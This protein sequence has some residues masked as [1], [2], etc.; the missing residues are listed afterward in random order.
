MDSFQKAM[1]DAQEELARIEERRT[2]LLQLVEDLKA[3]SGEESAELVPPPGYEPEGLTAEIRKILGLST[4]HLTAVQ[5]R[6]SLVQRGFSK[7][8]PKNLLIA[9]HTV[10][11]RIEKELDVA[12]REGKPVYKAKRSVNFLETLVSF[13]EMCAE[14]AKQSASQPNPV[15]VDL[16]KKLAE[17]QKPLEHQ[18]RPSTV[19]DVRKK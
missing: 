13:S 15:I 9:V 1:Q 5:I 11:G 18:F 19:I 6:D 4:V 8:N 14:A 7:A 3:L 16:A 2:K 12:E 17:M 10:L